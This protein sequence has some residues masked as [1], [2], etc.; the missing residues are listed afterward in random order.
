MK[1]DK[2]AAKERKQEARA[3][4]SGDICDALGQIP[5]GHHVELRLDPDR[6]VLTIHSGGKKDG[7]E[8]TLPYARIVSFKVE[9]EVSLVKSGNVFGRAV[10]GGLLFGSV[11]ALVGAASGTGKTDVSWY[12][13]LTYK[14]KTGE[15]AQIT[16]KELTIG[17]AKN[18][19]ILAINFETAVAA[20][21]SRYAESINEL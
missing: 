9:D 18:K 5:A 3:Y 13:T 4:F 15:Q 10:A 2:K 6:E 16:V 7:V 1:A 8:I 20:I 21:V 14:A 17:S 11:G 12:G 19:S